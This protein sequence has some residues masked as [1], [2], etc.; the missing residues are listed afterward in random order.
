MFT[1]FGVVDALPTDPIRDP[2]MMEVKVEDTLPSPPVGISTRTPLF[3]RRQLALRDSIR[4]RLLTTLAPLRMRNKIYPAR[5]STTTRTRFFVDYLKDEKSSTGQGGLVRPRIT[6]PTQEIPAF[7]TA[8]FPILSRN[9]SIQQKYLFNRVQSTTPL[10]SIS[11]HSGQEDL[12]PVVKDN[13]PP[14]TSESTAG[15]QSTSAIPLNA[16]FKFSDEQDDD[17]S[18]EKLLPKGISWESMKDLPAGVISTKMDASIDNS[19]ELPGEIS[20]ESEEFMFPVST[21]TANSSV[22]QLAAIN[23]PGSSTE[24]PLN[25]IGNFSEL[26]STTTAIPLNAILKFSDEQQ[27]D[28]VS[29]ED[30]LKAVARGISWE[31]I[32]EQ[33][34]IMPAAG[35]VTEDVEDAT[36]IIARTEMPSGDDSTDTTL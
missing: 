28:D 34:L 2:E 5:E 13:Q 25:K 24:L 21:R 10:S 22:E 12:L 29:L 9:P 19:P 35:E 4:S 26:Q 33:M 17:L 20:T 18:S 27:D 23:S 7:L 8:K 11:R 1:N 15:V 32:K 31:P 3:N 6:K 36:E 14:V 16:I 30:V